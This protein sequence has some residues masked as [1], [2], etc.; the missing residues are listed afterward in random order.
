MAVASVCRSVDP[1]FKTF[2]R[3][4]T[5]LTSTWRSPVRRMLPLTSSRMVT[6]TRSWAGTFSGNNKSLSCSL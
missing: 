1:W 6:A 5:E 3:S 2:K 4:S